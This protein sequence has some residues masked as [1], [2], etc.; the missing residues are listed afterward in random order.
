[1]YLAWAEE[2]GI[3][4]EK[5]GHNFETVLPLQTKEETFEILKQC[6]TCKEQIWIKLRKRDFLR[7]LKD[8]EIR[9]TM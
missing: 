3:L 5:Y 4:C 1:M 6:S 9:K 2:Q 8:N 7:L